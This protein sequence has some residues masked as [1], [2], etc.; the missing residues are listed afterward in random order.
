MNRRPPSPTYNAT[1]TGWP[2]ALAAIAVAAALAG[3]Q[4]SQPSQSSASSA[5]AAAPEAAAASSAAHSGE[6]S[7]STC[8][9]PQFDGFL[10]K[11]VNDISIQRR[12]VTDPLRMDSVDPNADPEPAPV[13][14]TVA[15]ADVHFPVIPS[16]AKQHAD[17]LVAKRSQGEQG[18]IVVQL[19]KPDTDYQMSF[20]F[21]PADGCWM[22][23]RTDDESL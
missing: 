9:A 16:Q 4:P 14:K 5:A 12:Y 23:Y 18:D 21:K 17:G 13:S 15:K 3:C 22:L 2:R 7:A 19:S 8:P 6:V 1:C 10:A 11:F 20:Y